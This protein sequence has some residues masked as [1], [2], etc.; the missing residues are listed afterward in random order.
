[1]DLRQLRYFVVL[2]EE[3]HFGRAAD[4][5]GMTQPPLSQ[6]ILALE[7]ELGAP[8]FARTKRTVALTPVGEQWLPYARKLLSDADAL[9]EIAR[10]LSRGET[11][12]LRLAFV[13]VADYSV[14]PELISQT[15]AE[16]PHV[17]VALREA[18][19]DVQI[20]ALLNGEIDAGLIIPPPLASLHVS[21]SYLK[22]REE[23]LVLAAPESWLESGRLREE[24]GEVDIRDL[25]HEPLLIFPRRS[26][27]GL[28]DAITGYYSVHGVEA[29]I[30]QE[31]IQMQTIVSLVSG[32]IGVAL[33]PESLRNLGRTGVR[34]LNL[35]GEPPRLEI[36]LA[37]PR[38]APSPTLRRFVEI[39]GRLAEQS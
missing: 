31:A 17:A 35:R 15:K 6:T 10:R 23:A 22:L 21:L 5:L 26:A 39:A 4:R 36:G 8:L 2:A 7:Q 14:L 12:S 3:L 33:V 30:G 27:P 34:Y 18:T 29:P 16:Y 28:H 11:G 13:S 32:G 20:V 25:L 9:P 37:W 24:G 1:M 19:S 38:K